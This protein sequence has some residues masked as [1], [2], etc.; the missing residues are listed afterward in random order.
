M[1]HIRNLAII[2]HVDHGKTTLVDC[3]LKQSG[4]FRANQA[5]A[6]HVVLIVGTQS[7]CSGVAIASDLV[8]TA[9]HCVLANGK[10]RLVT[11]EGRQA[12][13]RD[14]AR[15]VPHPQFSLQTG[16]F[17]DLALVKLAASPPPNLRPAPLSDRRA[18]A[19][20]GDRFIV[21]GFGVATKGQ[22]KS[23]GTLRM[24]TLV[25]AEILHKQDSLGTIQKGKF[26]D[27]IAVAGDPLK[28]ITEMQR[29]KFVMKGGEIIKDELTAAPK[30]TSSAAAK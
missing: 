12:S 2:A 22:T 30:P 15:V 10:Y 16:E 3:L 24:A 14:V 7:L 8:L 20:F 1:Q 13:V 9:A 21:A 5:I 28:D 19:S 6:R 17:Q 11:F 27:L 18:P 4:T 26:A 29:V 23:A 25:N